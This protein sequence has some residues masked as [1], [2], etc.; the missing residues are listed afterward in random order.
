MISN[1]SYNDLYS[2]N[3]ASSSYNNII[4]SISWRIKSALD[5][6]FNIGYYSFSIISVSVDH[7]IFPLLNNSFIYYTIY[8][9]NYYL[10]IIISP[11]VLY[12]LA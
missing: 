7:V 3:S 8:S 6:N 9:T 11:I 12:Y 4:T 1:N 2:S 10:I 5:I